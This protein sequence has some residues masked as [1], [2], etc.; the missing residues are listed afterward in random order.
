MY[1]TQIVNTLFTV[2][3]FFNL[4]SFVAPFPNG[5]EVT[6][7]SLNSATVNTNSFTRGLRADYLNIFGSEKLRTRAPCQ[8]QDDPCQCPSKCPYAFWIPIWKEANVWQKL[9]HASV[10]KETLAAVATTRFLGH[11][12]LPP[13]IRAVGPST[14]VIQMAYAVMKI[15][16]IAVRVVAPKVLGW[17]FVVRESV[18]KYI[19]TNPLLPLIA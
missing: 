17:P 8:S 1:S 3:M 11:R 14:V 15:G 2:I 7:A 4:L 13:E 6:D 5:E 18:D 16:G 10:K 19:Y 9:L 12:V